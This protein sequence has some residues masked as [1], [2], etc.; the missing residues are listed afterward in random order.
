MLT[1]GSSSRPTTMMEEEF[2]PLP[3]TPCASPAGKLRK[4][5]DTETTTILS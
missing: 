4:V 3:F 2:P 1:S 5:E